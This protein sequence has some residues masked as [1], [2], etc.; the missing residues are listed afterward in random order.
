MHG[1]PKAL[2][3]GQSR[4]ERTRRF[5]ASVMRRG[6][7]GRTSSHSLPS[8]STV[9]GVPGGAPRAS[10]GGSGAQPMRTFC[11]TSVSS[12]GRRATTDAHAHL[13]SIR[14]PGLAWGG[15][16]HTSVHRV[17]KYAPTASSSLLRASGP[18]LAACNPAGVRIRR[19][20]N[21]GIRVSRAANS[22]NAS[23]LEYG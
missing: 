6:R 7:E 8:V 13:T 20:C 23:E 1:G 16:S 18:P 15:A 19:N 11:R 17:F 5:S 3:V 9:A 22:S 2:L 14:A 12:E 21:F 10:V 4:P